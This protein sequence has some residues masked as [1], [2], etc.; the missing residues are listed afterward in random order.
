M[1]YEFQ[2][3][4]GVG[5]AFE[6]VALSV[7]EVIHRVSSPLA[8]CAVVVLVDD[9]IDDRVTEV[10][11]GV[12]HVDFGTKYHSTFRHRTAVHLFEEFEAFLHR[13]IAIRTVRTGLSRRALLCS[14]FFAGLLV[15]VGFAFL[16]ETYGEIPQLLEVV[17]GMIDV[18]PLESEPFD[19]VFDSFHVFRVLL[20][21]I[22]VIET[23]VTYTSEFL[24]N[25]E[26]HANGFGMSDVEIAVG[27]GRESGLETSSVLSL[28]EVVVDN[29]LDEIQA[30][31]FC[32]FACRIVRHMMLF[33]FLSLALRC[34]ISWPFQK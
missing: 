22:R 9:T 34:R 1:R 14:D 5:D 15:N 25:T 30:F 11:V 6:V 4:D 31:L 8:T 19:V 12:C 13:A 27:L 28:L 10:H 23:E 16:D 17:R 32:A 24:G 29:L 7:S 33:L 20:L 3:T 21:R 26:V 18:A 2:R